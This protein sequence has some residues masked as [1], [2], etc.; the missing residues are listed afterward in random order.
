MILFLIRKQ[1]GHNIC[2]LQT[3]C[4]GPTTTSSIIN[5]STHKN[6]KI[7]VYHKLQLSSVVVSLEQRICKSQFNVLTFSSFRIQIYREYLLLQIKIHVI[8]EIQ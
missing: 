7:N 5:C 6:N 8:L 1:V 4:S 3:R 2:S